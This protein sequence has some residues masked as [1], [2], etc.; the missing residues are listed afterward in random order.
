MIKL[1]IALVCLCTPA[2]AET[3]RIVDGDTLDLNGTRFRINGIDA[4]EAG[5]KCKTASGKDW[6]CGTAATDTLFALTKGQKVTCEKLATDSY[7]RSVARCYAGKTD[8]A[9]AMVEQ[10][11]AW[12]FLKFSDEY[13]SVQTAAKTAKIGIWRGA[14]QPAWDFRAAKWDVAKQVAPEGCPIK[15]NI[16]KNGKIYHA[17]WSPWYN[18]TKIN[19]AKGERWFCDEAEAVKAGWRAPY[20]K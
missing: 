2:M 10:G 1:L 3:L 18:R 6:A 17:P 16:T 9:R 5:Q 7:G 14:A 19:T 4:P 20:W 13:E 11:M 12:A 8:L 15:G